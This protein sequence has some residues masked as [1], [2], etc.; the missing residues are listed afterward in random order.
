MD[1][2]LQKSHEIICQVRELLEPLIRTP[3]PLEDLPLQLWLM[4]IV[5]IETAADLMGLSPVTVRK[6]HAD[7]LIQLDFDALRLRGVA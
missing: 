3:A 4:R 2:D 1:L 7:K 6:N 5:S